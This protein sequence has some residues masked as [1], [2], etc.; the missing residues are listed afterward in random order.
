MATLHNSFP[1]VSNLSRIIPRILFWISISICPLCVILAQCTPMRAFEACRTCL[2]TYIHTQTLAVHSPHAYSQPT[3]H[4]YTHTLSLSHTHTHTRFNLPLFLPCSLAPD[5]L[6]YFDQLHDRSAIDGYDCAAHLP[7]PLS[8]LGSARYPSKKE[9]LQEMAAAGVHG[10]SHLKW[11]ELQRRYCGG[12]STANVVVPTI[13]FSRFNREPPKLTNLVLLSD[14][15]DCERIARNHV[16]KMPD[17]SLFL[18][19]GVLSTTDNS[20]WREQRM[21]FTE[22]FLPLVS[23]AKLFPINVRRAQHSMMRLPRDAA[24]A[25]VD[26]NEFL[27]HEAMAQLQ[28]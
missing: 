8:E 16:T 14:P 22:A 1:N 15:E 17:Q 6:R 12:D 28:V 13:S 25:V 23:L 9:I 27:L 7:G 10:L 4:T 18:G 11:D 5:I 19:D 24:G 26:M 2:Y 3:A 20:S 21:H